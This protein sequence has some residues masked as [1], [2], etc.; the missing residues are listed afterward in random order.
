MKLKDKIAVMQAALDGKTVQTSRNSGLDC[1]RTWEDRG[2][3]E[4]IQWMWRDFDYRIKPQPRK[5]FILEYRAHH[6]PITYFVVDNN[7]TTKMQ[8]STN[9]FD[10]LVT[11]HVIEIQ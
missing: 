1:E 7:A 8:A 9:A 5:I 2:P 10:N 6:Q 4:A 11:V 3:A